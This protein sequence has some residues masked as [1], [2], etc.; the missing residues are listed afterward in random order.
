M[1][2]L[3]SKHGSGIKGNLG[4]LHVFARCVGSILCQATGPQICLRRGRIMRG[5]LVVLSYSDHI[6]GRHELDWTWTHNSTLCRWRSSLAY[7]G[8]CMGDAKLVVDCFILRSFCC[9]CSPVVYAWDSRSTSWSW[10]WPVWLWLSC[11]LLG[12]HPQILQQRAHLL[13]QVLQERALSCRHGAAR[14]ASPPR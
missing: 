5:V 7:C 6:L 1:H 8:V 9:I 13:R 3:I 4:F 14:A 10:S 11:A 12:P 2:R